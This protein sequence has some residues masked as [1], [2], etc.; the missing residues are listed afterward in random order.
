MPL[1]TGSKRN[2]LK[3][4]FEWLKKTILNYIVILKHFIDLFNCVNSYNLEIP[5]MLAR[6]PVNHRIC[7]TE[8]PSFS[9]TAHRISPRPKEIP[10]HRNHSNYYEGQGGNSVIFFLK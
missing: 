3:G 7:N 6:L 4:K 10:S 8:A 1:F 2:I 9:P 5:K